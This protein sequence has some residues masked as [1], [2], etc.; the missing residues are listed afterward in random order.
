[1]EKLKGTGQVRFCRII[2]LAQL[3]KASMDPGKQTK[4]GRFELAGIF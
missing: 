1:M 3:Y 2:I 4:L